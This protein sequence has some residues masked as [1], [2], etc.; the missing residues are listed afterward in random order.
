MVFR[1]FLFGFPD[2][3]IEISLSEKD[4]IK[5][6]LSFEE[7]VLAISNSNIWQPVEISKLAKKNF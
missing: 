2:E 4:L 1:R 3:E 6:N 7:I 5:Y